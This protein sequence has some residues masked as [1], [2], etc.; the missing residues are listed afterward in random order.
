[1]F[2]HK[3]APGEQEDRICDAEMK[4]KS[5]P[6]DCN[7][8]LCPS[9]FK[10]C[11]KPAVGQIYQAGYCSEHLTKAETMFGAAKRYVKEEMFEDQELKP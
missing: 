3:S 10:R 11:G 4:M 5:Q 6:R 9:P 2:K 1:M 7:W 8:V